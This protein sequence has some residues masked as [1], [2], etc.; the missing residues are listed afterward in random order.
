MAEARER[1]EW[2]RVGVA[3]AWVVNH[4]GFV[5]KP[6]SPVKV[7]PKPFRPKP[8]PPRPAATAEESRRGWHVLDSWL[9][10]MHG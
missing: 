9:G 5:R 3:V 2:L 8:P 6:V 7:I 4:G 10:G 1:A